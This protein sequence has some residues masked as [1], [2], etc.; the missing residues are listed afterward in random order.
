MFN[1]IGFLRDIS[2]RMNRLRKYFTEKVS[3]AR[4]MIYTR[5]AP[6]KGSLVESLLKD[7]S[8]VPTVVSMMLALAIW[9]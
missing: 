8:L 3:K 1:R 2:Q 6:I 7:V 4:N 9:N 5:G